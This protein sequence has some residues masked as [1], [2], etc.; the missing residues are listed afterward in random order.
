MRNVKVSATTA[1]PSALSTPILTERQ[2]PTEMTQNL[3]IHC[4]M[5]IGYTYYGE[6]SLI[7][8]Y[9]MCN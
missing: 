8:L 9:I 6:L 2:F 7:H 4:N 5:L 3:I 1:L